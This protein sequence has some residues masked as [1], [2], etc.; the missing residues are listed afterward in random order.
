MKAPDQAA[1]RHFSPHQRRGELWKRLTPS[2]DSTLQAGSLCQLGRTRLRVTAA[3]FRS[4]K[5][6][7]D[8][9]CTRI[10]PTPHF[11]RILP[12][13]STDSC[14]SN[15]C[16]FCILLLCICNRHPKISHY[17]VYLPFNSLLETDFVYAGK[18]IFISFFFFCAFADAE[19]CASLCAT[20]TFYKNH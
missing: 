12:T 4:E 15:P 19:G 9:L 17:N 3:P 2:R 10:T 20:H 11:F 5:V 8:P 18:E 1:W 7:Q 14:H 6:R 13:L 16:P